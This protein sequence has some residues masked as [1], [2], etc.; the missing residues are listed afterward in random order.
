M[1]IVA[2]G[3]SW[4]PYQ[5]IASG[6]AVPDAITNCQ[7]VNTFAGCEPQHNYFSHNIYT[8]TGS[9]AWQFFY[10]HLGDTVSAAN[11][12]VTRPRRRQLVLV[13]ADTASRSLPCG[14]EWFIVEESR[15]GGRDPCLKRV[16]EQAGGAISWQL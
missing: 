1:S 6:N 8:H 11:V 9:Q 12:A 7:G 13:G 14:A 16:S 4:S 15:G 5:T 10:W 2:S 3:I